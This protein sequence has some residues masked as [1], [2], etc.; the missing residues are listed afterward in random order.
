MIGSH[1]QAREAAL[2]ERL[3]VNTCLLT[4][5][6]PFRSPPTPAVRAILFDPTVANRHTAILIQTSQNRA[7]RTF[8]D[9]DSIS[10]AMDDKKYR[11]EG[12]NKAVKL[13]LKKRKLIDEASLD[14]STKVNGGFSG[15]T[16]DHG[17]IEEDKSSSQDLWSKKG[18]LLSKKRQRRENANK[19]VKNFGELPHKGTDTLIET[20]WTPSNIC[21]K[22]P[23]VS[24]AKNKP[25]SSAKIRKTK[26]SKKHKNEMERELAKNG[27]KKQHLL[28][29]EIK[30]EENTNE[31]N[32][33]MVDQIS[34]VDEDCSRGMKKWLIE[35]KQRRPGLKILQQRIDEF[36]TAHEAEQEQARKEREAHAAEGGWTVVA[37]HKGRKKT[38]EAETG[39]TVG[40]VAQ[41][42]V[43]DKIAK[44]KKQEPALNFYRFQRREAQR[45]EVMMLQSKFEQD[46]KRI[47]QLRAARKFRPY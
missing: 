29:T 18:R 46:R 43:M 4:L 14:K 23:D 26:K 20:I 24:K 5:L 8:F 3:K 25:S 31:I 21:V 40:S 22:E 7:T 34:A 13:K 17:F 1:L 19:T 33:G 41:A 45:N 42:A 36:I 15:N 35:H 12:S 32:D 6:C 28:M 9:F 2:F 16:E 47:Q 10:E 39:V 27:K 44:K 38:T 11:K 30:L 37:H